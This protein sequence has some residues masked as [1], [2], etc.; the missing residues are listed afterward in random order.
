[1]SSLFSLNFNSE[2][3]FRKLK[4][5]AWTSFRKV[6]QAKGTWL[7][8][9]VCFAL[10]LA[11]LY[12][13]NLAN[14]DFR[15]QIRPPQSRSPK[16]ALLLMNQ[17]EWSKMQLSAPNW[18]RRLKD[19]GSFSDTSFWSP[20][21]WTLLLQKLLQSRPSAIGISMFLAEKSPSLA[22]EA[23]TL[24]VLRDPRIYWGSQ[25]DAE[26]RPLTPAY[27]QALL[28][29]VGLLSVYADEDG[30][31]RRHRVFES[32][33]PHMS[34]TLAQTVHHNSFPKNLEDPE[35]TEVINF[36]G[37]PL[38]FPVY[39]LTQALNEPL[40]IEDMILIIGTSDLESNV[41]QTPVGKM[42]R[43]EVIA[44]TVDNLLESRSLSKLSSLYSM[45]LMGLLVCLCIWISFAYP[46]SVAL[47]IYIWVAT[48]YT[49]VS[50][51]TFDRFHI[52]LP[53][54]APLAQI[55]FTYIVFM[56]YQLT[57]QEN[58]SWQLEAE[59][60]NLIEFEQLKS[61]FVSLISHDLKTPIAKIQGICDRLL[62]RADRGGEEPD[63][64]IDILSLRNESSELNR[65]IQSI[66]RLSRV[67]ARELKLQFESS[68]INE[69]V[70]RAFEQL[71]PLALAKN[72]TLETDL[73]PIFLV[74][75]DPHLIFEVV[76][77]L[78]E[79]AIKYSPPKSI[80][81]IQSEEVENQVRISV[82]D[83][84]PGIPPEEQ[85]QVFSRFY[86]GKDQEMKSSG[87]GL[88]LY[89]VKYFV[90]LH[91]GKVF[92]DSHI[93]QGTRVGFSLPL[94]RDKPMELA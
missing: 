9:I 11:F 65:Y 74:E 8:G 51:W 76:L 26:E 6:W 29:N 42:T 79:N 32:E 13:E 35:D 4:A 3:E 70:L 88:G 83:N 68:D 92:L 40:P 18:I 45:L 17:Q 10:G 60:K 7:R 56:G 43:A 34:L 64:K 22:L 52:W 30:I 90:E 36:R 71:K 81:R 2:K 39:S 73:E 93:G 41:F 87:S 91:G 86:R 25:L 94:E 84:G 47:V 50:L 80:I 49:A 61:N 69:L 37:G 15:F 75:V 82:K 19:G 5:F 33:F 59:R 66:L 72:Q 24:S 46:Q 27:S 63:F 58:L 1:M 14:F 23:E 67:E 28:Q 31:V 48:L 77:N 54:F 44:T 62:S 78:I 12:A 53:L 57:L 21:Q 89:L 16:I 85:K 38:S 55:I 20:S